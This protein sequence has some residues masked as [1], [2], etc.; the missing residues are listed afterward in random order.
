MI[1]HNYKYK[2]KNIV[3]RNRNIFLMQEDGLFFTTQNDFIQ[4]GILKLIC[5]K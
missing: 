4:S 2:P 5:Q 1:L 3:Y